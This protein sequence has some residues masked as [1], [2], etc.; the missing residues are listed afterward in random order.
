MLTVEMP[1]VAG[2]QHSFSTQEW[3]VLW[4]CRHFWDIKWGLEP[5]IC[6]FMPNALTIWVICATHLMSWNTG[7]GGIDV[8][9]CQVNIPKCQ[10]CTGNSIH[11]RHTDGCPF[12]SF[13][14]RKCLDSRGTRT[15]N[16]R[17]NADCSGVQQYPI[18]CL[19]YWLCRYRYFC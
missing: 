18:S 15:P 12:E 14:D 9:P 13:W 5:P 8:F 2:Q 7:S 3:M 16:L 6:G 17:I 11:F 1:T 4:K 10:Q 19:E